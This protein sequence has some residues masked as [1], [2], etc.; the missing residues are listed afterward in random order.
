LIDHV[1]GKVPESEMPPSA[2]RERF[3]ALTSDEVALLRAWIDQGAEWPSGVSLTPPK[4]RNWAKR[5][6]TYLLHYDGFSLKLVP[7]LS[8]SER[9]MEKAFDIN[10]SP[11]CTYTTAVQHLLNGSDA[12]RVTPAAVQDT[13]V[14]DT[15]SPV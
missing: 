7:W 6:A 2:V 13:P 10:P 3:P 12:P 11:V 4:P 15:V 5:V 8:K 1:S 14:P 9:L